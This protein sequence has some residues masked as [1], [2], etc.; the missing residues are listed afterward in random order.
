LT[1]LNNLV[2]IEKN[3]IFDYIDNN[4]IQLLIKIFKSTEKEAI[5]DNVLIALGN[6]IAERMTFRNLALELNLFDDII[7]LSRQAEK[8][9][10]ILANC[11]FVTFNLIKGIP[12]ID[13]QK[14]YIYNLSLYQTFQRYLLIYGQMIPLSSIRP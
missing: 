9:P 8:P 11:L 1:V 10:K 4:N 3:L 14:V 12:N 5:L 2:V 7:A 6:I 13:K